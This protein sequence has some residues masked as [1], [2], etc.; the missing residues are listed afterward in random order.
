[1]PSNLFEY[2]NQKGIEM[3]QLLSLLAIIVLVQCEKQSTEPEIKYYEVKYVVSSSGDTTSVIYRD[4]NGKDQSVT[5]AHDTR[6]QVWEVKFKAKEGS[7]LWIFAQSWGEAIFGVRLVSASVFIFVDEGS[8]VAQNGVDAGKNECSCVPVQPEVC[9][10][11]AS[12][13][14]KI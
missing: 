8:A 7:D 2:R 4:Q 12:V 6:F 14:A 1:M 9:F 5:I 10:C 3:K 11:I 13:S